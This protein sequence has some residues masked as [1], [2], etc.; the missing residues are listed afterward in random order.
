MTSTKTTQSARRFIKRTQTCLAV[1]LLLS[2]VLIGQRASQSVYAIGLMLLI[3][4]VL[5]VFTF[6]NIPEDTTPAGIVKGLI[7]TWVITAGVVW[8]SVLAAPIL[9]ALGR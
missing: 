8:V 7:A 3:F 2:L 4:T 6:N 5:L 9:T 1:L